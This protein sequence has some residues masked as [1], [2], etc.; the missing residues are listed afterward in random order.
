MTLPAQHPPMGEVAC[1]NT[2]GWEQIRR[3][4]YCECTLSD[5]DGIKRN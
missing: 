3:P 4:D 2:F 5:S 1:V